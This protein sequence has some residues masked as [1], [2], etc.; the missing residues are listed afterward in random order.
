MRKLINYFFGLFKVKTNLKFTENSITPG[1]TEYPDGYV[2]SIESD[3]LLGHPII[4]KAMQD[5]FKR[6]KND[7]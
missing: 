1:I 2:V 5:E 6:A 7:K 3:T 4:S